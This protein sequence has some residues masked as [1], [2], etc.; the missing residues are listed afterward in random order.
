MWKSI[1]AVA[2]FL[3]LSSG[4]C[5]AQTVDL[6]G[7]YSYAVDFNSETASLNI[8]EI[9]NPTPYM[10][11]SLRIELWLSDSPYN[12]G[13]LVGTRILSMPFSQFSG[14]PP[15]GQLDAYSS[16]TGL[17]VTGPM[18]ALPAPGTYYVTVVVSEYTQN[19]G[20][21]DGYCIDAWGDFPNQLTV[22][23][24]LS[25]VGTGAGGGGSLDDASL[26]L[27][28]GL[29]AIKLARNFKCPWKWGR[30]PGIAN[31]HGGAHGMAVLS[32]RRP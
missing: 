16:V 29:L 10:T 18:A 12:G 2:M 11:G 31:P 22:P 26:A 9:D 25:F 21:S 20:T 6:V 5:Y 32:R 27:F 14:A 3:G 8:N 28:A 4:P 30:T 1:V 15:Y 17:S 13:Q 19:C 24:S 23:A 7:Q